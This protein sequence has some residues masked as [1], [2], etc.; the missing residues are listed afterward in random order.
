MQSPHLATLQRQR[1]SRFKSHDEE[2]AAFMAEVQERH[3]CLPQL[4]LLRC[5]C[6][7]CPV[8]DPNCR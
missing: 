3:R 5:C 8:D 7:T 4:C 2:G 6:K 1:P